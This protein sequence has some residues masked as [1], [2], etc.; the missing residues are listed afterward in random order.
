MSILTI[1]GNL[2]LSALLCKH[3][4]IPQLLIR[5]GRKTYCPKTICSGVENVD[6]DEE[7]IKRV[8]LP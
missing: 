4:C 1:L 5:T 3:I 8:V 7:V 6:V 2:I